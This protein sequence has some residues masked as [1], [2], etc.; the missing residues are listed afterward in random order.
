M[1]IL[2]E[3]KP[4]DFLLI[5]QL[6]TNLS[7]SNNHLTAISMKSLKT[8]S[9]SLN[10]LLA[11][12]LVLL[13]KRRRSVEENQAILLILSSFLLDELEIEDLSALK[14]HADN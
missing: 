1:L 7:P 8:R 10:A 14:L 11:P 6:T 5:R 12:F 13:G 4:D 3:S 9:I 2:L